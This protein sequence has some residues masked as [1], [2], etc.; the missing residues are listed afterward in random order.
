MAI[1]L[2]Q[3]HRDY[4]DEN[5]R[6]QSPTELAR[7]I[8]KPVH[9]VS[10]YLRS[11]KPEPPKIITKKELPVK[12]DPLPDY[13]CPELRAKHEYQD[14]HKELTPEEMIRFEKSYKAYFEQFQGDV[15]AT[16]EKQ[17]FHAIKLEIFMHR[18]ERNKFQC[19]MDLQ[20]VE[21]QIAAQESLPTIH[22][23]KSQLDTFRDQRRMLM[24][25][26]PQLTKEWNECQ[27]KHGKIMQNIR[28][29][30]EQRVKQSV[31][32]K[33]NILGLLKEFQKKEYREQQARESELRKF[34]MEKEV[35]RL[36]Q[37]HTYLDGTIDRPLLN[38]KTYHLD[39]E[40]SNAQ[41]I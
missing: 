21:E 11:Q 38:S 22:Q 7:A 9:L 31:D 39:D 17:I 13:A 3:S 24:S 40:D 30:R 27:D 37:E 10:E 32:A 15:M 18:N 34:A 41:E 20:D 12:T 6:D 2:S 36:S 29:T 16:E 4:I 5:A 26:A 14:L 8:G 33:T 25:A 19:E 1:K 35:E 23:N 28:G